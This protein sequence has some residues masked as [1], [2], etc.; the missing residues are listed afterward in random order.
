MHTLEG[1]SYSLMEIDGVGFLLPGREVSHI[2][3][4][5]TIVRSPDT[6]RGVIG[7][8]TTKQ[9]QLP[10]YVPNGP[11]RLY[12]YLPEERRFVVGLKGVWRELAI[13]CDSI[14]PFT[15]RDVT[16]RQPLPTAL[17]MQG[18]PLK[19]LL[20]DGERLYFITD[21]ESLIDYLSNLPVD[22]HE[23]ESSSLAAER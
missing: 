15:P 8:I 14:H 9:G 16:L 19:E 13:A 11:L 21:A 5:D 7:H 17:A 3:T 18:T 23:P 12:D 10:L 22:I 4:R 6:S 20:L 1:S 2:G